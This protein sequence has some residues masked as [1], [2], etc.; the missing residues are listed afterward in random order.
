MTRSKSLCAVAVAAAAFAVAGSAHAQPR[1]DLG[2]AEYDSNC[3]MCH[4]ASGKGDGF[5]SQYLKLPVPDLTAIAKRNGGVFPADRMIEVID[6]RQALKGHGPRNMPIWGASYTEQANEY[7]RGMGF[8]GEQYVRA[9]ILALVD[10]LY[11][12]QGR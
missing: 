6:G 2:K 9:R 4:G 12:L 10:Y 1:T 3:V 8:S 5:Y 7:Y 11:T